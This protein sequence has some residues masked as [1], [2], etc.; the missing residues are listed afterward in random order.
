VENTR[1]SLQAADQSHEALCKLRAWKKLTE[2]F[3]NESADNDTAFGVFLL[4]E[5]VFDEL[6]ELFNVLTEKEC[7][8]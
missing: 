4:F 3:V 5:C 1:K 2:H 7:D 8:A 6:Q